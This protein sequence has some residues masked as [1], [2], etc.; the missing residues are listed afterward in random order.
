MPIKHLSIAHRSLIDTCSDAAP[1]LSRSAA[2]A[3]VAHGDGQHGSARSARASAHR[4]GE[5]P[6]RLAWGH[7]RMTES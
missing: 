4:C 7:L 2:C 3:C 6:R 1:R 5:A